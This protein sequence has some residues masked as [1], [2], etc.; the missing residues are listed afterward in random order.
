MQGESQQDS[1]QNTKNKQ[2]RVLH[3]SSSI[4]IENLYICIIVY[5]MLKI[6]NVEN[7]SNRLET[8]II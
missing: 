3:W 7:E 4:S 1:K 5:N 6:R 8:S 2:S